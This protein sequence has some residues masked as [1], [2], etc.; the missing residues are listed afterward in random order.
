[1]GILLQA[2][3]LLLAGG[4]AAARPEGALFWI[5]LAI[6]AACAAADLGLWLAAGRKQAALSAFVDSL[7]DAG[8]PAQGN[9][10]ERVH[11]ALEAMNEARHKEREA[12]ASEARTLGEAAETLRAELEAARGHERELADQLAQS[13]PVLDKAHSVC[14]KLST[15][16][17]HLSQLVSD[18]D[19]G[20]EVQR[21]RLGETGGAM[22]RVAEAARGSSSRVR[23]V[24]DNAET[25]RGQAVTGEKEVHGAVDSIETVKGTILHLKEA[26]AGLGEKARDIGQV[27]NVINEVADQTNLLALN[28]A[29]EAAR[30]GEAGRGF[31]VVADEV[32]KLAEK[33]MGATKEVEEA[34]HA[35]QEET[36]L[37]VETVDEAARLTVES[38]ERASRAGD[39][40]REIVGGMEETAGHLKII[41]QGAAEQSESSTQTNEALEEIRHVAE[42]TAANMETFTAALLSFKS[43][44]EELDMI[45]NAL[46]TGDYA[47]AAASDKFVQ[48]TPKLD[49]RVPAI[50]RQ[51]RRLCDY[52]NDLYRAMKNNRTGVELQAIV[53]K[54]RDYTA[55]HFSDEEKIFVPSQYPGT[56]EHKAIHRKFVAKLDE[57]EA[58]LKNGTATVS[59]DLLSFLK[60]WLINHIA[61]T[62]PTYLPYIQDMVEK[63]R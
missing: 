63:D 14:A 62:D 51:H 22:E 4:L 61:G 5:L 8:S 45:V 25:S 40:M 33:T 47:Q 18:V 26:M 20:V 56:K 15:D 29:I 19:K 6:L 30:A 2:V 23:E 48:W 42:R 31:A 60:D 43:G 17:G 24:S 3:I 34:V 13:A 10:L 12:A 44:M 36:R 9:G 21:V 35:I 39:F 32:R 16:V 50:D 55:S 58:Q 46:V 38:A 54:L 27:M 7:R 37:N 52:I 59:M 11:R 41:A 49:L 57:F 28:A 53:K 1:M